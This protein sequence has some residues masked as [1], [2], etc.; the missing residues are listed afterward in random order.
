MN[1]RRVMGSTTAD[2]VIRFLVLFSIVVSGYS[3]WRLQS[4]VQCQARYN[5][6]IIERTRVL[7]G[8]TADERAAERA[9]DDALGALFL[10]PAVLKPPEARTVEDR[11]RILAEFQSY[12]KA[13]RNRNK[14]RAIADA[15]R[16][17]HPVPAPPS[18]VCD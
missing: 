7:T 1:V 16:K 10:D 3:A 6:A 2:M 18:E 15:D 11:S 4:F 9:A 8:S 17:A 14:A 13:V 12:L 5:D